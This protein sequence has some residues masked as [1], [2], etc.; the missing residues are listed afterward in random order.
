MRSI[1]QIISRLPAVW[2]FRGSDM[3]AQALLSLLLSL[4]FSA[5]RE[6]SSSLFYY[7][8]FRGR[9]IHVRTREIGRGGR[10]ERAR[11]RERE[12]ERETTPEKIETIKYI[13][14]SA[15]S[16]DTLASR[17]SEKLLTAVVYV[18][19]CTSVNVT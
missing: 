18:P 7:C 1:R 5:A 2:R 11:A 3:R 4:Y 16:E 9:E 13:R 10:R 12:R 17:P 19:I 15:Q 6:L 14:T 8:G